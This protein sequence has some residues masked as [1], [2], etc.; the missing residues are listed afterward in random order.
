MQKIALN[1]LS[2][3]TDRLLEKKITLLVKD[4][5]VLKELKY[6]VGIVVAAI[7]TIGH[8]RLCKCFSTLACNDDAGSGQVCG[9]LKS[10]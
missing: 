7:S 4:K 8:H 9:Y 2:N 5:P 10:Y 3:S 6:L 1:I